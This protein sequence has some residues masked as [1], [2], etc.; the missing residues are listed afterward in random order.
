MLYK[1]STINKFKNHADL[2]FFSLP[3][4]TFNF[5]ED[6][7]LWHVRSTSYFCSESVNSKHKTMTSLITSKSWTPDFILFQ[8]LKGSTVI[9]LYF[10]FPQLWFPYT[11]ISLYFNFPTL[12]SL[13]Y[14][15]PIHRW[16]SYRIKSNV[17]VGNQMAPP[18]MPHLLGHA[19]VAQTPR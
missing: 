11:L 7:L 3:I 12:I 14:D 17:Y 2:A 10:N 13:D 4:V 5:W 16:L 9:S 6:C 1:A 19:K 15:F 8:Y 18:I